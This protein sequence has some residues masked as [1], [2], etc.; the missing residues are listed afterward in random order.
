MCLIRDVSNQEPTQVIQADLIKFLSDSIAI[1]IDL[2][3][4]LRLVDGGLS[5]WEFIRN[6]LFIESELF[7]IAEHNNVDI[8]A[9]LNKLLFEQCEASGNDDEVVSSGIESELDSKGDDNGDSSSEGGG[10]SGRGSGGGS[11]LGGGSGGDNS[12]GGSPSPG[13]SGSPKP[14]NPGSPSRPPGPGPVGDVDP[15]VLNFQKEAVS[16]DVN[17][18]F[19]Y[20]DYN[21]DGF[22]ENT[23]WISMGQGLLVLDRN[24]D[25]EINDGGELF[26]NQTILTNG[27][28]AVDGYIALADLDTNKDKV[29]DAKDENWQDLRVWLDN[30]DGISRADELKTMEEL[31]IVS[32]SLKQ[33]K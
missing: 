18:S 26:G 33:E 10:S 2:N 11:S 12:G 19:S 5:V 29:I 28:T 22:A 3:P 25:G 23:A 7:R 4:T 9:E 13:G 8:K 24:G 14:N 30:G 6:D 15:V 1:A 17:Y 21:G 27:K 31:G 20:F 32:L 16:T